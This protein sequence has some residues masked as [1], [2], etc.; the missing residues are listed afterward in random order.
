[1]TPSLGDVGERAA[2]DA[3]RAILSSEANVLG[4]DD[5]AAAVPLD[6]DDVLVA[7]TDATHRTTHYPEAAT[8]EDVGWYAAAVTVSDVA[9]MGA[10]PLGFLAALGLPEA[11]DVAVLEGV[12]RG[13]QA[14]AEAAGTEVLGG[15]TKEQPALSVTT[16][17]L[18]RVARAE[19]LARRDAEPGHR[20][21]VTGTL[22]GAAAA[23]EAHRAGDLDRP[24]RLLRPPIRVAEG[25]ALATAGAAAA[26]DLSDGLAVALHQLAD[27]A[28][29]GLR[30]RAGD[31]PVDPAARD[32]LPGRAQDLALAGGGDFE[33]AAAVP[34]ERA[35]AVEE[36][37]AEAGGT[38][39]WVGEV[40][41]AGERVLERG[42][43]TGELPRAGWEHFRGAP[44]DR[45]APNL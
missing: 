27:A 39:T 19:M 43:E 13:L 24:E 12:A 30:V 28:D 35:D 33:L 41:P 44:G 26:V 3:L 7:T 17:G 9:A 31:L 20:L 40:L 22:G 37:V 21:G 45:D 5:D 32:L 18:G 4:Y 15:D 10:T 16:S 23:L 14:C 34:P 1:M 11:T 6:G 25:R 8:P 29:V 42:E 2:I 38:W 36:A